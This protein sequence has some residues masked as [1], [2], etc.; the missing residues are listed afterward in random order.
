MATTRGGKQRFYKVKSRLKAS[1]QYQ[2]W[3]RNNYNMISDS[4]SATHK[5]VKK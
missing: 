5:A 2:L 4:S 1:K 3:L